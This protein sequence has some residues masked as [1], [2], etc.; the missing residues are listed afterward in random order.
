[1]RS[2]N[3]WEECFTLSE[4]STP[5]F[6]RP[7][8][9]EILLAG[10]SM[11]IIESIGKLKHMQEGVVHSSPS[12]GGLVSPVPSDGGVVIGHATPTDLYQDFLKAMS[13]IGSSG[14]IQLVES[15]DQSRDGSCDSRTGEWEVRGLEHYDPLMNAY[16]DV[17][18]EK[19]NPPRKSGVWMSS[20]GRE[21][22]LPKSRLIPLNLLIQDHLYPL[23]QHHYRMVRPP[24]PHTP[25]SSA[26]WHFLTLQASGALVDLLRS[27]FNLMA[28]VSVVQKY[29]LMEAGAVMHQ[30]THEI[31]LRVSVK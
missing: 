21:M 17:I 3:Y 10:K 4:E 15:C 6:L 31:F 13:E 7:V 20:G 27:E 5:S 14:G 22:V 23:L 19:A 29:F 24:P 30:F 12:K 25:S 2:A 9:R 11:H 1:M 16:L 26:V 18:E 28:H 8:A